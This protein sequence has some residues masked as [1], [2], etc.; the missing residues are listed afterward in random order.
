MFSGSHAVAEQVVVGLEAGGDGVAGPVW[1]GPV[2]W[3]D[4]DEKVADLG[5]RVVGRCENFELA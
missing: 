4:V 1:A 2:V 3:H 5:S